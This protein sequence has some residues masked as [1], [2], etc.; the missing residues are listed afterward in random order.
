MTGQK[1]LNDINGGNSSRSHTTVT[2][3]N[4][5]SDGLLELSFHF[6]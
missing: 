2:D 4:S 5:F 3:N 1:K 6:F